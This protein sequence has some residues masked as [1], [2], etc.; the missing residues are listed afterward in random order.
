M[1]VKLFSYNVNF[2]TNFSTSKLS[3][4]DDKRYCL[5]VLARRV[6]LTTVFIMRAGAPLPKKCSRFLFHG[7]G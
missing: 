4:E 6:I 2:D 3:H 5:R 1:E 7:A